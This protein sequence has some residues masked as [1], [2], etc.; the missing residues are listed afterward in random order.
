MNLLWW[1]LVYKTVE[2][3]VH[4]METHWLSGKEKVLGAAASKEDHADCFG[5]WKGPSVLIS[6]RK[7]ATVNS[8]SYYQILWQYFIVFIE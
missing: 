1:A 4:E 6:L 5:T 3:T 2:K 7:C 8:A